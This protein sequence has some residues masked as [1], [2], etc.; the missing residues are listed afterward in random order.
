MTALLDD[1]G[2][3]R[4]DF[5]YAVLPNYRPAAQKFLL[6]ALKVP[7]DRLLLGPVTRLGHCFSADILITLRERGESGDLGSGDRLLASTSGPHSWSTMAI[8]RL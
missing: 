5:T 7:A 1:L 2:L 4:E 3:T 8:Q 6:A